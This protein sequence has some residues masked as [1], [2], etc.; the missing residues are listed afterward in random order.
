MPHHPPY[1]VRWGVV[2]FGD[3]VRRKSGPALLA[4]PTC[5]VSA[6]CRLTGDPADAANALGA[7]AERSLEAMIH[8]DD[9]DAIYIATPPDDHEDTTLRALAAGKPILVE[10][11][12]APTVVAAR[13]MIEA[14]EA[15]AVPLSVAYYRRR[16]PR[17]R[18]IASLIKSGMIGTVEAVEIAQLRA[19]GAKPLAGWRSDNRIAPGGRFSDSHIHALDW[20]RYAFGPHD[21]VAGS[22]NATTGMVAYALTMRGAPVAGVFHPNVEIAEDRLTVHG[23][24]GQLDAPIFDPGPIVIQRDGGQMTFD[25]PD[26]VHPHQPFF[27]AIARHIAEGAKSPCTARDALGATEITEALIRANAR[28][29][30]NSTAMAE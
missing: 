12:L 28:A 29:Q 10:K 26:P 13:R 16:N 21:K 23:D 7:Q 6:I 24:Q 5:A 20:L 27:A 15:A 8:R 19:D 1:P 17:L 14:A 3:V 11:P 30:A 18:R 2:G 4:E 25:L 9:V 22:L